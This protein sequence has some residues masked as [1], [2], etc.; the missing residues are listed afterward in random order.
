MFHGK[1]KSVKQFH[2]NGETREAIIRSGDTLL[3]TLRGQMGL[4]GA[5]PA[6]ENGDCGACTVLV[7]GKPMHS[8]LILSIEAL[9]KPLL[10]IEGLKDS[11]IQKAFVEKWAIQCGYCTPGFVLKCHAL[12]Q[13]HPN[14]SDERIE[15]WLESNL[16]RCTGYAEIKEAIKSV[17]NAEENHT[18]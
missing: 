6:C 12:L 13:N 14:A 5:K 17:L 2:V 16:C 4:S 1:G 18:D 15:E 3:Q 9:N 8:C 10:T 11:P 7:D